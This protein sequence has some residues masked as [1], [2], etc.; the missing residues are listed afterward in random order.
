MKNKISNGEVKDK[1]VKALVS[2]GS[3]AVALCEWTGGRIG[4]LISKYK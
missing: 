2:I 3:L 4:E 1:A